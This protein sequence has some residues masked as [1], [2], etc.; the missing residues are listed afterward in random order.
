MSNDH[1]GFIHNLDNSAI[2]TVIGIILLF[3]TAIAVTLIAPRFVDPSWTQPTT[4]YQVQI[5]EVADPNY[6][7]SSSTSSD[8]QHVY[9][10]KNGYTLLA[11]QE[12]EQMHIIAPTELE[13]YVTHAEEPQLKLTSRLLLLRQPQPGSPVEAKAKAMK[14]QMQAE[15]EKTHLNSKSNGKEEGEK[16]KEAKESDEGDKN[17]QKPA[18]EVMELYVPEGQ[19]AFAIG[20]TEGVV[21]NWVD[22]N[23]II[24]SD[25]N[26]HDTAKDKDTEDTNKQKWHSDQGVIYVPNPQEYRI[27]RYTLYNVERWQYDPKG[28]KI[29]S[30]EELKSHNL[31]FVSRQELISAGEHIYSIEGCWYCH[32]DQTRTLVQDVVLNGSDSYPAPPSSANEYIYQKITFMSTRRIGPDLSRVGIKRPNRDWHKSHFWSPKTASQGSIMPSFRHFFDNDPRGTAKPTVVGVPN[33]KF[34]AIFQYLMTKGTRITPP[35]EA[36][37]LGKDPIQ[38]KEIIEG[39][40]KLP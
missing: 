10:I 19:S 32:S 39:Q 7:I 5:Y 1:K 35:T 12:H 22:S 30:L 31:G 29:S 27:S 6:Y 37:W 3:S 13:K 14:E 28:E 23:F 11:F 26:D 21:E 36:W 8:K 17:P 15:W 2:I 34:E 24:L 18:F 40:R 20:F 33:Y 4:P 16:N 25:N 38:T 9:H